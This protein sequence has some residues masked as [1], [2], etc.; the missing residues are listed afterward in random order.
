MTF[1]G[2]SNG[3]EKDKVILILNKTVFTMA[4]AFSWIHLKWIT[5]VSAPIWNG[6]YFKIKCVILPKSVNAVTVGLGRSYPFVQ[7][8]AVFG[9]PV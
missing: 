7:P 2:F 9:K 8:T 5:A 1:T 6:T 3:I 4:A